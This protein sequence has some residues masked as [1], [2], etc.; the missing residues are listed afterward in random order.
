M[1]SNMFKARGGWLLAAALSLCLVARA[2]EPA[3]SPRRVAPPTRIPDVIRENVQPQGTPVNTANMPRAVRRAVVTDAARRFQVDENAVVLAS[4]EQVIWPDGALG[5]P[6]PGYSYPQALV[7][8][9]RVTASTAAGQMR[10]HTDSGGN[11]VTCGLPVRPLQKN[12]A[13]STRGKAVEP[14]TQ[15]PVK[16]APDR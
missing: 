14:R 9:Y 5:C 13:E 10:Y 3:D 8:G 11:V 6:Q 1:E 7:P 4:A 12:V 2:E 16:S 15:P